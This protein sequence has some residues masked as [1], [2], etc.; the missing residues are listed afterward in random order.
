MNDKLVPILDQVGLG[1]FL[2]LAFFIISTIALAVD[3]VKKLRVEHEEKII[4]ENNR[5]Q[6]EESLRE[7]VEKLNNTVESLYISIEKINQR[8]DDDDKIIKNLNE[9]YNDT[10]KLITERLVPQIQELDKTVTDLSDSNQSTI[11]SFIVNEYHK[12][13]ELGY[14]DV[15]SLSVIQEKYNYYSS[16]NGNTFIAEL[17]KEL[18]KLQSKSV[19]VNDAG[20]DPVDYFR[21]HPE[22]HPKYI[23]IK[24]DDE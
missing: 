13:M 9:S 22:K 24:T 21:I 1:T 10:T 4:E 11:R 18:N 3:K 7:S 14:I 8:L 19:I 15:Y 23:A 16:H 12:W 20:V 5:R 6:K 17:V 2:L